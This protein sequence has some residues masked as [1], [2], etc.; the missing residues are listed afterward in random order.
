M[1]YNIDSDVYPSININNNNLFE[2]Y[3]YA[4]DGDYDNLKINKDIDE[5]IIKDKSYNDITSDYK[6]LQKKKSKLL[7]KKKKKHQS[8]ESHEELDESNEELDES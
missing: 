7:D 6:I 1:N 4:D 5:H 8:D 2:N 3:N